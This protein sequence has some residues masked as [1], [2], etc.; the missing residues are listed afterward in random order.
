MV[1]LNKPAHFGGIKTS[2][3]TFLVMEAAN[4]PPGGNNQA[5]DTN[6]WRGAYIFDPWGDPANPGFGAPRHE[7]VCNILF[8]DGHVEGIR[9]PNKVESGMPTAKGIG[10]WWP[11][12]DYPYAGEPLNPAYPYF[13]VRPL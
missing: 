2:T 4:I 9:S 7:G 6:G 3:T 12:W 11:N 5:Q 8:C 13:W 1:Y 10:T